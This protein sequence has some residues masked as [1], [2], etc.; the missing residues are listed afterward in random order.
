MDSLKLSEVQKK[1][2]N[3]DS[4]LSAYEMAFYSGY[5]QDMEAD[6]ENSTESDVVASVLGN[7]ELMQANALKNKSGFWRF[8]AKP[9]D[10]SINGTEFKGKDKK[11]IHGGSVPVTKGVA[12]DFR[13]VT[14]IG[15]ADSNS[16]RIATESRDPVLAYYDA[17][18]NT[19]M[20]LPI[21]TKKEQESE[22][23]TDHIKLESR[24][25]LMLPYEKDKFVGATGLHIEEKRIELLGATV[26]YINSDPEKGVVGQFITVPVT[27]ASISEVGLTVDGD[28][29]KTSELN[30]DTGAADGEQ[31]DQTE[32]DVFDEIRQE[33]SDRIDLPDL[34]DDGLP[35]GEDTLEEAN[36]AE[37]VVSAVLGE[38]SAFAST[39][40][41]R[42]EP[43]E[44][45]F[46]IFE[47]AGISSDDYN[48]IYEYKEKDKTLFEKIKD[49]FEETPERLADF[50]EENIRLFILNELHMDPEGFGSDVIETAQR[51][52]RALITKE[53]LSKPSDKKLNEDK[54]FEPWEYIYSYIIGDETSIPGKRVAYAKKILTQLFKEGGIKD[55][56]FEPD[57][58]T[59]QAMG[60]VTSDTEEKQEQKAGKWAGLDLEM[61]IIPPWLFGSFE[62]SPSYSLGINNDTTFKP[63]WSSDKVDEAVNAAVTIFENKKET[64]QEQDGESA[65]EES[66]R[67]AIESAKKDMAVNAIKG[68]LASIEL[69]AGISIYA[70]GQIGLEARV[71]L[72]IGSTFLMAVTGGLN[73]ELS[74]AGNIDE[75]NNTFFETAFTQNVLLKSIVE[76]QT[77]RMSDLGES[78]LRLAFGAGINA[79]VSADARLE[80]RLF[81][82]DKELYEFAKY[83]WGIASLNMDVNFQRQAGKP[84]LDFETVSAGLS[85][86]AFGKEFKKR[87]AYGF[88]F[89]KQNTELNRIIDVI[90]SGEVEIKAT[91]ELLEEAAKEEL[92]DV[93][94]LNEE[95]LQRLHDSLIVEEQKLNRIL[96][97]EKIH[98]IG[99]YND[100]D[101]LADYKKSVDGIE[102]HKDRIKKL[103]DWA[104]DKSDEEKK[105]EAFA[106]YKNEL[107]GSGVGDID[108]I[109]FNE[110]LQEVA[111]RDNLIKYENDRIDYYTNINSGTLNKVNELI[112]KMSITDLDAKNEEFVKRYFEFASDTLKGRLA[113]YA[114]IDTIKTYEKERLEEV[115]KKHT[116]RLKAIE[117]YIKEKEIS[118]LEAA[119]VDFALF[120][121][122]TLG[123]SE[124]KTHMFT[125]GGGKITI[126]MLIQY[127]RDKTTENKEAKESLE[128]FDEIKS[129]KSDYDN[130]GEE[131]QIEILKKARQ[132]FTFFDS[133][134]V[135]EEAFRM[136]D[137]NMLEAELR[138]IADQKRNEASSKFQ[139]KKG[140]DYAKLFKS[141]SKDDREAYLK[142][143]VS[144]NDLLRYEQQRYQVKGKDDVHGYRVQFL[145]D[146]LD[147]VLEMKDVNQ[148]QELIS[149][150]REQ[151]FSGQVD[152][153]GLEKKEK[154]SNDDLD[155]R[156]LKGFLNDYKKDSAV[157][158]LSN[159]TL[160]AIFEAELDKAAGTELDLIKSL[161]DIREKTDDDTTVIDYFESDNGT[162]YRKDIIKKYENFDVDGISME[163]MYNFAHNK[164]RRLALR[165]IF[166]RFV[167]RVGNMVSDH[168]GNGQSNRVFDHLQRGGHF[169]RWEKLTELSLSDTYLEANPEERSRMLSKLYVDELQGGNGIDD[170]LAENYELLLTPDMAK[171]Y[172]SRRVQEIGKKHIDRLKLL[173]GMQEGDSLSTYRNLALSD[174]ESFSDRFNLVKSI[175]FKSAKTGAD[176][177][178]E[179]SEGDILTPAKILKFEEGMLEKEL[180]KHRDRLELLND[181]DTPDEKIWEEYTNAGAGEGFLSA[182]KEVME[183]HKSMILAFKYNSGN[184]TFDNIME[185]ENA[186]QKYYGERLEKVEKTKAEMAVSMSDI[187]A[188]LEQ[189]GLKKNA[190]ENLITGLRQRG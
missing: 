172:E 1:K 3:E 121:V 42:I 8:W 59:K 151:Y 78:N 93:S 155:G 13:P 47:E 6:D 79:G 111:T 57:D 91:N 177:A 31:T 2:N 147:A 33:V 149:L 105:E 66:K 170:A 30:I 156:E 92:K 104:Q 38:E 109:L 129:L 50:T 11:Q 183:D 77:V 86:E 122:D 46:E 69:Q 96:T 142:Q 123:A 112:D 54:E 152:V 21:D 140:I 51:V 167:E 29:P 175:I 12:I 136:L 163:Q 43:A 165:G 61:P 85:A 56:E 83:E 35:S 174:G 187:E 27:S 110:A 153:L 89:N 26:S 73:A 119:N 128:V 143:L 98:D 94:E 95:D 37:R 133:N 4:E 75:D 135:R 180:Q 36:I 32:Q 159:E 158:Y 178:L 39:I 173:E 14:L 102:K 166:S 63:L 62:L 176:K 10:F 117:E 90:T 164:T 80:S 186:R 67:L 120:Y 76:D 146:A 87:D 17:E 171:D 126:D 189:I 60:L 169:D 88:V 84:L 125:L 81:N 48:E 7:T 113:E 114:D 71:A 97:L 24:A 16:A 64:I 72:G 157:K 103:S 49:Y 101:Y 74:L 179:G 131:E 161:Q 22:L 145:N 82:L 188:I 124:L 150:T 34:G 162:D 182:N 58:D 181:S 5:D 70:F 15:N 108:E 65:D 106:Y 144:L 20:Q 25:D 115:T 116:T 28:F 23:S 55:S 132:V 168:F 9:V 160:Q 185:H 41:E 40:N 68:V 53:E 138:Q 184:F 107:G 139:S 141:L 118:N 18:R 44:F 137:S 148:Q 127:E 134:T 130:A 190:L 52:I 99:I 154:F 45:S 100:K 19:I